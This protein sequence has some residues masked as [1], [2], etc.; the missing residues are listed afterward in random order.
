MK[1][2]HLALLVLELVLIA[3]VADLKNCFGGEA[4]PECNGKFKD[5]KP[6]D[7]E[8]KEVL[9]QHAAWLTD[10]SPFPDLND[11]K[12]ANDPRRANL[13]GA[14]LD[15][16]DLS[17]KDLSGADLTDVKLD[18]ANL[19]S[20]NLPRANLSNAKLTRMNLGGASFCG[21]NL[22]GASFRSSIMEEVDLRSASLG[23][24]RKF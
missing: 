10:N 4:K 19:I 5:R 23:L 16:A 15:G 3:Q 12:V 14:D 1:H 7:A 17:S 22:S 13:C 21:A 20:A 9:R 6:T 18:Q 11:A 8:L 24:Q 2:R